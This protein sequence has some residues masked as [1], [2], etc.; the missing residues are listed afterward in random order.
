MARSAFI[1]AVP[2]IRLGLTCQVISYKL[3]NIALAVVS[4]RTLAELLLVTDAQDS[5]PGCSNMGEDIGT[6]EAVNIAWLNDCAVPNG[7]LKEV[8]NRKKDRHL[9]M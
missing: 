5:L 9:S 8:L 6:S 7:E 1:F 3:K 2:N 4:F